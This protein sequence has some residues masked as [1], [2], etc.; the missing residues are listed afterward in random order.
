LPKTLLQFVR[1]R[2]V[3]AGLSLTV[4]VIALL[5]GPIIRHDRSAPTAIDPTLE[6]IS[7]SSHNDDVSVEANGVKVATGKVG[8]LEATATGASVE[9]NGVKVATGKVG[10]LEATATGAS[11]EANGVKIAPGGGSG[12]RPNSSSPPSQ[13]SADQLGK[14]VSFGNSL[15]Q[16][17]SGNVVI[18]APTAMTVDDVRNVSV[19]V[20][21]NVRMDDL[22]KKF[23]ETD[24]QVEG[25]LRV[26]AEMA[27]TLTGAGFKIEP[28]TS[29]RQ[30]IAESF[31]TEWTWNVTAKQ[32]GEQQLQILLYAIILNGDKETRLQVESYAQ[33]VTVSVHPKT[34]GEQAEAISGGLTT[35]K[36]IA[37]S[38]GAIATA[39]L[40]WVGFNRSKKNAT[41]PSTYRHRLT[42][43]N[44][45]RLSERL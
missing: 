33:Q 6:V 19:R 35:V 44:G 17:P 9:A 40:T 39:V 3:Q 7:R 32:E 5:I 26:S 37:I 11:V 18:D 36:S 15:K 16:L 42:K 23:K 29:E 2:T 1:R 38:L 30:N 25:T 8:G 21:H 24:Q 14:I 28:N 31:P 41:S 10:G 4:I 20:G 12:G 22:K 27:A 43:L 13:S 34:W 45:A